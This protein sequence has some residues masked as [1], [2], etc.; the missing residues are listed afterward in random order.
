VN[1]SISHRFP[2]ASQSIC[3]GLGSL[4]PAFA[5]WPGN[6]AGSWPPLLL[7][8]ALEFFQYQRTAD[9]GIM[10]LTLA[11]YGEMAQNDADHIRDFQQVL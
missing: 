5:N 1:Q 8:E 6:N 3:S 11:E 7:I 9:F 10:S 4:I 2:H